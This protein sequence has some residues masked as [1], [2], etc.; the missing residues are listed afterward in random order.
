LPCALALLAACAGGRGD[1]RFGERCGDDRECARGLCV[2]G[3]AGSRPVCTVSCARDADCPRGWT[4]H[5]VTQANVL[6][7]AR[8]RATPIDRAGM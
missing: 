2:S 5:G 3:V 6:V 7:C 1:R 8:G 4:C